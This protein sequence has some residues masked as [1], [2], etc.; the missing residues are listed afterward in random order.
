MLMSKSVS[1]D[2]PLDDGDT[3]RVTIQS[4]LLHSTLGDGATALVRK[5][6]EWINL[7]YLSTESKTCPDV[8]WIIQY[9]H[10]SGSVLIYTHIHTQLSIAYSSIQKLE[11]LVVNTEYKC[12]PCIIVYL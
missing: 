11:N 8:P 12:F 5:T 1:V 7:R 4:P 9:I 10:S 3:H 6:L 2:S